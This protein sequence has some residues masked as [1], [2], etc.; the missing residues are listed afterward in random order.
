MR[1]FGWGQLIQLEAID[2]VA[3][4]FSVLLRPTKIIEEHTKEIHSLRKSNYTTQQQTR[5]ETL[6]IDYIF[7]GWL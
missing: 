2:R 1:I 7:N 4:S 3:N 6:S 5:H